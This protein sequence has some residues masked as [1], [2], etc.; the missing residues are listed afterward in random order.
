MEVETYN[1]IEFHKVVLSQSGSVTLI[2]IPFLNESMAV[3][4]VLLEM[5]RDLRTTIAGGA[6]ISMSRTANEPIPSQFSKYSL[7]GLLIDQ[8][9]GVGN[10]LHLICGT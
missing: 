8:S 10:I 7:D 2:R 4:F 5:E 3:H 6:I 9:T 1:K